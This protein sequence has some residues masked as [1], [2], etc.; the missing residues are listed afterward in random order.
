MIISRTPYRI[1]F[2]G[3]GTDYP[4]WYKEH[5]GNVL[6]TTINKYS[7]ITCRYL[8]PFFEHKYRIV[9]SKN[10]LTQTIS[11]IQHPSVRATLGYMGIDKGVEIHHDGDLPARSGLGSSSSFTVG[12]VHALY[13]Q[14][15][16][17]VTK[18]QLALDA[19]H[20]E[21]DLLKENVGAQDQTSAAFGGF[22]K[23]EFGGDNQ[24]QV[25]PITL[26]QKKCHLLQDNLMLFFTGFS[27]FASEIAKEQINKTADK[28]KELHAMHQMVD[29]AI[30]ILNGGDM[31]ITDFGRLLHESWTIKRSLTDKISTLQIDKIYNDALDAG[32]L[33][34]KLLGA[35]GGG[36]MLFFVEPEKQPAVK[37]RLQGLLHVPFKFDTTGSQIIYYASEDTF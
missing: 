31:D 17:M 35:G 15:G 1:S 37:K 27:R 14:K 12:L 9:Y 3:G 25:Q 26:N 11:E 32:A 13:A 30:E 7:Y 4:V 10:E 22:N 2:F 21:Q 34:G 18:R 16:T 28:Q 20:I 29:A 19:I 23:I 5:G 33:G 6:A 8:P 24:I 36:F